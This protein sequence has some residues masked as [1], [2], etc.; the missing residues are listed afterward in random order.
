[1]AICLTACAVLLSTSVGIDEQGKVMG[2]NMSLQTGAEAVSG[3]LAGIMAV[4]AVKLPLLATSWA[5][6]LAALILLR[7]WPAARPGASRGAR[8]SVV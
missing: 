4:V 5:A 1:M 8:V 2:T 7:W 6:V 3:L